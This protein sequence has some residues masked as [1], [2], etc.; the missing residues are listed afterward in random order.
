MTAKIIDGK[1]MA[2]TI[3]D[4]VKEEVAKI[5]ATG[6]RAPQL[7]VILVGDNAASKT[8]VKNKFKAA[9]YTCKLFI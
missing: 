7:S 1:Q 2:Q 3:K 6:K 5:M 8:Y 4:E 9:E